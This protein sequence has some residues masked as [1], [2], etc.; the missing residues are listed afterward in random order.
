MWPVDRC[1]ECSGRRLAF[2]TAR[3]GVEYDAAVRT[4]VFDWKERGLR[5]L[6][7]L[8]ASI[9]AEV[10]PPPTAHLISFVPP[11]RDRSLQRGHHPP[12]RL[13]CELGRRWELPVG[14][15]LG[16]T[17]PLARQR[18]LS[19]AARRRN[20][21]GAF[22]ARPVSGGILLVDDVYTTGSTVGAAAAALRGAGAS[23]VDVVT[24]ARAIRT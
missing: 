8:A 4:L 12:E 2:V 13:A 6:T 18:G 11:D 16:R 7:A 21:R 20:V 3:A 22:R 10:V 9:V 23:R 14:A 19:Q 1:R 17:R 15:L 24:F 5:G